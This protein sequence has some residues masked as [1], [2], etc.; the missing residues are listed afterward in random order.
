[1]FERLKPGDDPR[2]LLINKLDLWVQLHNM[3][4]GFI[5]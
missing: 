3:S 5:S 4:P 1:M 2:L